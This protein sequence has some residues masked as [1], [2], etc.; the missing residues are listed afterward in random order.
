MIGRDARHSV[1]SHGCDATEGK[2]TSLFGGTSSVSPIVAGAAL[3]V[4]SIIKTQRGE[5]YVLA[6]AVTEMPAGDVP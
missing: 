1:V 2:Y 4:E 3:L 5:G 6:A